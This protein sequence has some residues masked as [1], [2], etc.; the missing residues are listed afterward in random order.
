MLKRHGGIVGSSQDDYEWDK[1]YQLSGGISVR[2]RENAI[3]LYQSIE[4]YC[5]G[6]TFSLPS[7]L[8]SLVSSA[9]VPNNAKDDILHF[10]EKDQT[11]I[12][13]FIND[14][15]LSTLTVSA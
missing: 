8:K 5:K 10:A 4:T 9:L 6:N 2:T 7:G 11:C 14:R 15:L 13:D 3:K 12:K 1:H